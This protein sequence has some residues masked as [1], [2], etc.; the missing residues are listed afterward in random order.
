MD[1]LFENDMTIFV[2]DHRFQ[3]FMKLKSIWLPVSLKTFSIS[4]TCCVDRSRPKYVPPSWILA[5]S[6]TWVSTVSLV[7]GL[8]FLVSLEFSTRILE[9]KIFQDHRRPNVNEKSFVVV[10]RF[11]DEIRFSHK[12]NWATD[13][14]RVCRLAT[15]QKFFLYP[16]ICFRS[17]LLL[18]RISTVASTLWVCVCVCAV[19]K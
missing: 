4:L 1:A 8:P 11:V 3:L 18:E 14:S 15:Q 7:V 9:K 6:S 10:N 19:C 5:S 16:K 2:D 17:C 13:Q 12:F